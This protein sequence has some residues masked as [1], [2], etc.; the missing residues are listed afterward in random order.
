[1]VAFLLAPPVISGRTFDL[2]EY[3]FRHIPWI[4]LLFSASL[5]GIALSRS[6]LGVEDLF[7]PLNA[8]R[9]VAVGLF[10]SLAFSKNPRIH[11]GAVCLVGGL[12]FLAI[13]LI[14]LEMT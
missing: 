12:F 10:V 9:V 8:I 4:A 11:E 5:V 3:Y 1:M 14:F 6:V 2:R 7:T 13:V